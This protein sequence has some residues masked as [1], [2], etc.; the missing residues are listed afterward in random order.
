MR[1]FFRLLSKW[2]E[3][4]RYFAILLILRI[5]FD[6]VRT[7]LIAIF[8][9]IGFDRIIQGNLE[10]LYSVCLFYCVG[11]ILLFLF[12][13]TIWSSYAVQYTKWIVFVRQKIFNHISNLSLQKIESKSSGEWITNLNADVRAATMILGHPAHLHHAGAM[14]LNIIV[15][16]II[17]NTIDPVM[18]GLII[19]FTV[20]HIFINQIITKPMTVLAAEEKETTAGN[21]VDLSTIIICADTAVLYDAKELLISRFE[22]SSR[23]IR[24]VNMK[25]RE[26]SA[27]LNGILPVLGMSGYLLLLVVGGIRISQNRM[28]FGELTAIFQYRGGVQA[29]AMILL[30]CIVNIKI[31]LASIKRINEIMQ[32]P[33]EE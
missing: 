27:L 24:A 2:T 7:I 8:A 5:P 17:L 15:S 11:S 29:C 22:Q 21:A 3:C 25:M 33:L 12:N 18:Y 31:S 20:P 26:R 32:F 16:S 6:M 13:G 9:Q 14:L 28:T 10:G 4:F 23:Q 1:E 19:L 30:T